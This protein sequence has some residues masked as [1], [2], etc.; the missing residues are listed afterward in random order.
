MQ[1][2]TSASTGTLTPL[3]ERQQLEIKERAGRAAK[4][5]TDPASATAAVNRGEWGIYML[6]NR[7]LT[8]VVQFIGVKAD[9][10]DANNGIWG[11]HHDFGT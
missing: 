2:C 3:E 11:A 1:H 4:A 8:M 9:G 6:A 5:T 10:F 7:M